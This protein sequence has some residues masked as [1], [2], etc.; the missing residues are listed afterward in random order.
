M[1]DRLRDCGGR[2]IPARAGFTDRIDRVKSK[3]AD[4][5]RSRGVYETNL[6]DDLDKQGSSPLARGLH[7]QWGYPK[8][9]VRI[10]PARAGFTASK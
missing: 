9:E 4:H 6:R 8:R 7:D 1:C 2:I 10:I 5:P 3:E